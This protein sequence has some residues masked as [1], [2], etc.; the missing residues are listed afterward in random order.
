MQPLYENSRPELLSELRGLFGEYPF[1]AYRSPEA[2]AR[3]L[4]KLR[5]VEASVF[6]VEAA[7]EALRDEDGEILP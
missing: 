7:M 4:K 2:A 5:D 3:V 1:L 6:A